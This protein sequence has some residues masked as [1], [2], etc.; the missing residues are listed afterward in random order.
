MSAIIDSVQRGPTSWARSAQPATRRAGG[1]SRSTIWGANAVNGVINV[2]DKS[3]QSSLH[4]SGTR[5]IGIAGANLNASLSG[6]RGERQEYRIQ[7]LLDHTERNQPSAF[8][9][10]LDT[11]GTSLSRTVRAPSR[12]GAEN[13]TQSSAKN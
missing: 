6:H 2:I 11:V 9:E 5:D 1:S 7:V 12:I 13:H 4:Q 10:Y 3:D 8:V